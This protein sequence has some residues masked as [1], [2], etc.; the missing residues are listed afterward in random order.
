MPRPEHGDGATSPCDQPTRRGTSQSQTPLPLRGLL[1]HWTSTKPQGTGSGWGSAAEGSVGPWQC[2]WVIPS[3][4]CIAILE[5]LRR[6]GHLW[7][8]GQQPAASAPHPTHRVHTAPQW[9]V[10]D[11]LKASAPCVCCQEP[12]SP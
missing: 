1:G 10:P 8:P 3:R 4:P 9:C 12:E 2:G 5:E 11:R 7:G 6:E